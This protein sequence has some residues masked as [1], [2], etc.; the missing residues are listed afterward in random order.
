MVVG[1]RWL[2]AIAALVVVSV[3]AGGAW[4]LTRPADPLTVV[5]GWA[6]ARNAGDVD[7]AL[8]HVGET[9]DIFGIGLHLPG[10]REELRTILEA[11]A[12]A[13]FRIDDRDCAVNGENVRCRYVMSDEPMRRWGLQLAGE[14]SYTVRDGRLVRSSRVHD[15]EARTAV[16]AAAALFEDWVREAHPELHDVIWTSFDSVTYTTPDGARAVMALLDE[17]DTVRAAG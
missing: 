7:G 14:H 10:G 16:Y 6:A 12:I 3:A 17:Y 11:Q 2:V 9:G 13:G 1:R 15:P 4:L 5:R 8:A